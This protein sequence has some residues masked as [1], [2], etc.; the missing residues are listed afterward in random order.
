MVIVNSTSAPTLGL[1]SSTVLVTDKS[2]VAGN[3]R[4]ASDVIFVGVTIAGSAIYVALVGGRD[5]GAIGFFEI[6]IGGGNNIQSNRFANCDVA[7]GPRSRSP[8]HNSTRVHCVRTSI[9]RVI[10]R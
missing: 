2:A 10:D 3:H 9:R 6:G 8:N 7:D 1:L 5:F 4:R